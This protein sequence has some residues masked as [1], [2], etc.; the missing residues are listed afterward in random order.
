MTEYFRVPI[1]KN[2][3]LVITKK[4]REEIGRFGKYKQFNTEN[5]DITL[6]GVHKANK[7]TRYFV[8][9]I[10]KEVSIQFVTT[11]KLET[12]KGSTI[13]KYIPDEYELVGEGWIKSTSKES[14]KDFL[15]KLVKNNTGY[16]TRCGRKGHLLDK[17]YAIKHLYSGKYLGPNKYV[18]DSKISARNTKTTTSESKS[19]ISTQTTVT[20]IK[21]S[22]KTSSKVNKK[23]RIPPDIRQQVWINNF[24]GDE[25][26][27]Y[28]C[29][30]NFG[31]TDSWHCG[32]IHSENSGGIISVTNMIP[33]CRSCNLSMGTQNMYLW[34]VISGHGERLAGDSSSINI[35]QEILKELNECKKYLGTL[36]ELGKITPRDER[37]YRKQLTNPKNSY[38][39][40]FYLIDLI[41][42]K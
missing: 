39:E 23:Q 40:L 33:V 17:C 15:L 21:K 37:A 36:K 6:T 42:G 4:V 13:K 2:Y 28:C 29:G 30:R 8:N 38:Q 18:S 16:C 27:C 32:H 14:S 3:I 35:H 25:G 5:C 34:M 41:N 26:K 31:K 22:T 10:D 20:N 24:K 1:S 11:I 9:K 12:V 7:L 19:L